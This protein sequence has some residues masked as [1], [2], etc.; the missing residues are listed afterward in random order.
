MRISLQM[1]LMET[2]GMV[3]ASLLIIGDEILSGRTQD[4]N[5]GYL[6]KWLN[7]AGIQLAEVRVVPDIE[8]EIIDA[9][10]A[11]RAKHDYV[12]TTGGIG[13]THDDITSE[14]I[15]KAFARKHMIHPEAFR[16]LEVHYAEGDFTKAR[17]RMAHTPEGAELVDNPVSIA[18]GFQVENVFVLA[19][20]PKIM[21]AMLEQLRPRLKGGKTILSETLAI[22]AP[23]SEMAEV[24]QNIEAAHDGL[25][26]GSYPFFRDGAVG[27]EIVVRSADACRI[28]S[29]MSD[30]KV[31]CQQ[32]SYS[33]SIV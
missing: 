12:F 13:P 4:K 10:N 15:A 32:Q 6:A 33:C 5:L 7:E 18:P 20:V 26:V 9:V 27:T 8:Q 16:R 31:F 25:S 17:Q 11:L 22:H 21:Q 2:F 23:E 14:S 30:L 1:G 19:G 3:N 24:L 29:A 28:K